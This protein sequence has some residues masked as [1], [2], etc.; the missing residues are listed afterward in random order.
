MTIKQLNFAI[1][2]TGAANEND[3][4]LMIMSDASRFLG[5]PAGPTVAGKRSGAN[6]AGWMSF[7]K[8]AMLILADSHVNMRRQRLSQLIGRKYQCA[9]PRRS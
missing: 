3:L 4:L 9:R 2:T 7:I 8:L 5:P 1:Q 6:L